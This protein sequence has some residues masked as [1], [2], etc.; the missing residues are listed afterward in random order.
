MYPATSGFRTF[1]LP[2]ATNT[3]TRNRASSPITSP[4]VSPVPIRCHQRDITPLLT[5]YL[6][7]HR[8]RTSSEGQAIKNSNH[9]NPPSGH[10]PVMEDGGPQHSQ[11]ATFKIRLLSLCRLKSMYTA[12]LTTTPA[13]EAKKCTRRC[14]CIIDA[15]R[16]AWPGSSPQSSSLQPEST[17]KTA[18]FTP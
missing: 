17:G 3:I 8:C 1:K 5:P 14:G 6:T 16:M 7:H 11:L 18:S 12:L 9:F 2:T 4:M 13:N 15:G 10:K